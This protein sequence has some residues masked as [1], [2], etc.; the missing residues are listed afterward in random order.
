MTHFCHTIYR[1]SDD[2]LFLGGLAPGGF[3]EISDLGGATFGAVPLLITIFSLVIMLLRLSWD[4]MGSSSLK[5]DNPNF[6]RLLSKY[7]DWN[8]L[9]RRAKYLC[10]R[11]TAFKFNLTHGTTHSQT[12]YFTHIGE[13]T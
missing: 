8:Y 4:A 11:Y 6:V 1:F 9:Q 13:L 3:R 10:I 7:P 2:G 5:Y 12:K